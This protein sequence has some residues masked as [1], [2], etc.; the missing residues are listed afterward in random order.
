MKRP[1]S[2]LPRPEWLDNRLLLILVVTFFLLAAGAYSSQPS[3]AAQASVPNSGAESA[4]LPQLE[5]TPSP[6]ST[7]IQPSRT[8]YPPELLANR[9]QTI[10]ISLVAALLVLI[11]AGG[12]FSVFL[13]DR[14]SK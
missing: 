4:V 8:P 13:R 7:P 1:P 6:E 2:S 3:R 11:V 10:G 9:R 14:N 5:E 12:V